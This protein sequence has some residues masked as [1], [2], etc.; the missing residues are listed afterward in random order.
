MKT[1]S[2]V[3]VLGLLALP[4]LAQEE[5][6]GWAY[7]LSNELLSPF[8]PGVSLADCSS[9]SAKSLV[10]W[11]V[12]QESA[13]R[14]RDDVEQELYARYGEVMRPTPKAEGIGV[15]AYVIPALVFVGGGLLIGFFLMR[16][17]RAAR[18]AQEAPK[19]DAAPATPDAELERIV[20]EELARP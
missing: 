9:G 10:M 7:D 20:D 6:K 3:L 12:V 4:A 14:T 16:Q 13:G 5:P 2:L 8:C 19:P 11:M 1:A 18:A 15:T 17:T